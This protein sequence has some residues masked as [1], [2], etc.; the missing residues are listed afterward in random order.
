MPLFVTRQERIDLNVLCH[1][2]ADVPPGFAPVP[3]GAFQVRGDTDNPYSGYAEKRELPDFLLAAFPVTCAEY[4]AFLNDPDQRAS[5]AS[6]ARVPREAAT[7]GH[8]WPE[9]ENGLFL[10]PTAS[11][12]EAAPEGL[13]EKARRLNQSP[14]DWEE[15]WPIMSISWEDAAAYAAWF[16]GKHGVMACLPIEDLWEKA[17]RGVD[18]R[19]FTWGGAFEDTYLNCI[20][21]QEGPNRPMPIDSYPTDESPYGLRGMNGNSLDWCLDLL[22]DGRRILRGGGW[23]TYGIT[24]RLTA[25][26]AGAQTRIGHANGLRLAI[27]VQLG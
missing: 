21:S 9:D 20:R 24:L 18:G 6:R 7:T 12:L 15:D 1:A 17:A 25:R 3:A 2:E 22:D 19:L 5:G 14:V 8:Y 4:L 11:W 27:I 26:M 23:I 13:K 10:I 16:A